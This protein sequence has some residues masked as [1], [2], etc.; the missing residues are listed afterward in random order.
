[1][2]TLLLFA[3]ESSESSFDREILDMLQEEQEKRRAMFRT[4]V[5]RVRLG[6]DNR[7]SADSFSWEVRMNDFG[8]IADM[9]AT[10]DCLVPLT[11]ELFS[12]MGGSGEGCEL[13]LIGSGDGKTELA[14]L[15]LGRIVT[16]RLLQLTA[17]NTH[18][19]LLQNQMAHKN[20]ET[21]RL[22]S[23]I[24]HYNAQRP[25]FYSTL[26][27]L[28]WEPDR[29]RSTRRTIGTLIKTII[30]GGGHALGSSGAP[31]GEE[32][33]ETAAVTRL[34]PPVA[35][36]N[37]KVFR[38]LA[39]DFNQKVLAPALD[40]GG[41]MNVHT[42]DLQSCVLEIVNTLL[43]L[44]RRNGLPSLEEL[45]MI[46]PQQNPPAMLTAKDDIAP[47]R[48]WEHIYAI[49]GEKTGRELYERMYPDMDSLIAE[50]D[51]QRPGI[52]VLLLRKVLEVGAKRSAHGAGCGFDQLPTIIDTIKMQVLRRLESHRIPSPESQKYAFAITPRQKRAVG[53][54]RTRH[55]LLDTVYDDA[56]QLFGSKRADLR[57]RMFRSAAD[58]A[59]AYLSDCMLELRTAFDQMCSIRDARLPAQ[60]YFSYRLDDAYDYWCRQKLTDRIGLP[61]L[62]ECFTEEICRKPYHEAAAGICDRL[63]TLIDERTRAAT[64]MIK[65]H[66]SSF[67]AELKY[68]AGL[69]QASDGKADDL[70]SKLLEHLQ[71]QL[72]VP[73]LMHVVTID[74]KL[75]PVS[76]MFII[77][78]SASSDAFAR[79]IV[80]THDGTGILNDPYED[81]VQMIVK[82]A[83]NALGDLLVDRNNSHGSAEA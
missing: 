57:A 73:P 11:T 79:L 58:M 60:E 65:A 66:I 1:M 32:W 76:R 4:D 3:I 41:E 30:M 22:M 51:A 52:T 55:I 20:A 27:M 50:Y 29:Q 42:N 19:V 24:R 8:G 64:D 49:Y 9:P 23:A 12:R 80:E 47:T 59:K 72:S 62:Y 25:A 43:E 45:Y 10:Q 15:H 2:K 70:D 5:V 75:T 26:Y 63:E 17:V 48:A 13:A 68:R 36:I 16:A 35:Q 37:H 21:A 74:P 67:F 39:E 82:Y 34:T 46:M 38:Y 31:R 61:E 54:A 83:G 18:V 44:E 40:T 71:G 69:L 81:G 14:A 7:F 77:H 28:P 33:I 6:E 78:R 56:Q 53:Y